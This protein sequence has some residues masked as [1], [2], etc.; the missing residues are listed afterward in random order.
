MLR[1][2][3]VAEDDGSA[4]LPLDERQGAYTTA[5]YDHRQ[6]QHPAL[7]ALDLS[8]TTDEDTPVDL[9]LSAESASPAPLSFSVASAPSHG[10]LSGTA[11]HLTYTPEANFNGVDLFTFSVSDGIADSELA[12]VIITVNPVNDPPV[13]GLIADLAMDEGTT[14]RV[15]VSASDVDGDDL[16]LS[17][18]G[19]PPFAALTDDGDGTGTIVLAP[20]FDAAGTYRAT[21]TA[22]D[23]QSSAAATFT[24]TVNNVNRPPMADAGGPYAVAEGEPITLD[25]SRSFDPDVDGAVVRYEWDLD[26]D[27]A[28]DDAAGETIT[29]AFGDEGTYVVGLRVTDDLGA[30]A[31]TTTRVVVTNVAPIV[32]AI[33]APLSAVRVNATVAVSAAFS[34]PGSRDAHTAVWDWNDGTTSAGTVSETA[35]RGSITG[36][37]SYRAAGVYTVRLTVTDEDGAAATALYQY[38]VVYDPDGGFVTGGGWFTSPAG[39]YTDD[40]GVT[41]KATFSFVSKYQAGADLPTGQTQLELHAAGLTF[42]S[43]SYQWLVI[44]HGR[45]QLKGL[46]RIDGEGTFGLLVTATDGRGREDR[47]RLKIWDMTTGRV[48]YDSQPGAADDADPIALVQGGAIVVHS[49]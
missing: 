13:L 37:H 3:R 38:V 30:Q 31:T 24:L 26:G 33:S 11:P 17:L 49:R 27:G 41:G 19:L 35:G 42:H 5:S 40:P 32:G 44:A 25:A 14:V 45:A 21:V 23:G 34:D 48:V 22:S 43:T 10:V 36:T 39:A 29:T 46:G 16:S 4:L 28:Y 7:A 18:A 8:A 20:G 12:T 1:V 15:A 9:T 6:F 47:V 2:V